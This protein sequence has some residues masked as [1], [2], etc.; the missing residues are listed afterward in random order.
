MYTF[1]WLWGILP[2]LSQRDFLLAVFRSVFIFS[3]T[4]FCNGLWWFFFLFLRKTNR[5]RKQTA[6]VKTSGDLH[7]PRITHWPFCSSFPQWSRLTTCTK[8][9]IRPGTHFVVKKSL[10]LSEHSLPCFLFFQANVVEEHKFIVPSQMEV[11]VTRVTA[12]ILLF[13][14][15]LFFIL[16]AYRVLPFKS[17]ARALTYF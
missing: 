13:F 17:Q 4:I 6:I 16:T 7:C 11:E 14:Y 9:P 2:P 8:E 3:Y 12:L 15:H 5:F 10:V 1:F